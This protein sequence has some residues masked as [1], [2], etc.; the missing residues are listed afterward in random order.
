MQNKKEAYVVETVCLTKRYGN[1]EV[2]KRL[3]LQVPEGA[4]YGFIGRNGAGKSTTL[5][6]VTGLAK[7]TEG[8]I[9]LFGKSI[10]NGAVRRRIGVLVEAAGLYPNMTARQNLVMKAKC[11]GLPDERGVDQVLEAVGLS[12]TGKKK[13]KSPGRWQKR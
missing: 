10:E 5:K 1:R 11:M 8:E 12:D 7:P 2:I 13:I 4:I 9:R 3:N 6:L